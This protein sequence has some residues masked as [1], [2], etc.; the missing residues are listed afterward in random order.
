MKKAAI[1][2]VFTFSFVKVSIPKFNFRVKI[3][4]VPVCKDIP[5]MFPIISLGGL[6]L[7]YVCAKSDFLKKA[8]FCSIALAGFF[9]ILTLI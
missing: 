3:S 6:A 1:F 7:T 8:L 9:D 5:S 4:N 2:I